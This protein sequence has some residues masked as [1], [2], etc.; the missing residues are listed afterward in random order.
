MLIR[1]WIS[2]YITLYI[3]LKQ[4]P[5]LP[6]TDLDLNGAIKF[7]VRPVY[8]TIPS[9]VH[10]TIHNAVHSALRWGTRIRRGRFNIG[11]LQVDRYSAQYST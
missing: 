9:A 1:N 6:K 8:S 3:G 5:R 2:L 10:T 7:A 11:D 4:I